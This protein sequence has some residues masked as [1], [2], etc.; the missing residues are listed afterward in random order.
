M[1][2][3][4]DQL[5]QFLDDEKIVA[6]PNFTEELY[7]SGVYAVLDCVFSSMA[8]FETVVVPA[9]NR[10]K[11]KSGLQDVPKLTFSEY[12]E[13]VRGNLS[14]T[15]EQRFEEVAQND[16]VNG[17]KISKRLKVQIA[18]DVCQRF[19]DKKWETLKDIQ[20]LPKG[21]PFTC[22]NPGTS[23][24]LEK[25]VM[26]GIAGFKGYDYPIDP[27]LKVRGIGLALGAYLMILL[28]D[29]TF[30][31]PDTL[32]LR[33]MGQIGDPTGGWLPKASNMEDFQLIRWAISCAAA[34]RNA[35]PA[36]LDNA[37]WK[38]ESDR[39]AAD[40]KKAALI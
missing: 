13:H 37:L 5:L 17:Q 16:F 30:V 1:E 3:L 22:E 40:K 19:V 36:S 6:N 39:S 20:G 18:Y 4:T 14:K 11:E 9:L 28:G 21:D 38:Y 25:F 27:D 7:K 34:Q 32:L 23:G 12:L 8:K 24:E 29:E 35:T 10:F 2:K 15:I 33:L 26:G 31:K